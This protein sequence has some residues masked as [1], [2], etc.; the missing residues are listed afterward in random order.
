MHR[1]SAL[2]SWDRRKSAPKPQTLSRLS[3]SGSTPKVK[4]EAFWPSNLDQE[5][6]KAARILKSFCSMAPPFLRPSLNKG[7]LRVTVSFVPG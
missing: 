7:G 6:D 2:L 3:T 4:K 5:C 1:V